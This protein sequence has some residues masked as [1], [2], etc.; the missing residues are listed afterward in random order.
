MVS[1]TFVASFSAI[2][3]ATS[4]I[5]AIT[6]TLNARASICGTTPSG[7]GSQTPLSTLTTVTTASACL[8]QCNMVSSCL[9]FVFGLVDGVDK[10]MLY[11]IAASSIP[12]ANSNL[13]A[14]DKACTSVPAVVP[15]TANPQGLATTTANSGST[16]GKAGSTGG[17]GTTTTTTTTNNNNDGTTKA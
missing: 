8:A 14:Y 13:V 2:I 9:S 16:T 11:A 7:S 6:V 10:C 1:F 5:Y 15:T 3:A 4:S 12:T 17:T